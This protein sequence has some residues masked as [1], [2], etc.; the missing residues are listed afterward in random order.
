[1]SRIAHFHALS[2]ADRIKQIAES[3]KG[4][5]SRNI[6]MLPMTQ[7]FYAADSQIIKKIIVFC[8]PLR[9]PRTCLVPWAFAQPSLRHWSPKARLH[10]SD[11][12]ETNA[13]HL[14]LVGFQ[15]SLRRL[16]RD[17]LS[18]ACSGFV[19][20]LSVTSR[21]SR[22]QTRDVSTLTPVCREFDSRK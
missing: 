20:S 6:Y 21:A 7:K 14:E 18:R 22:R 9:R 8:D 12:L 2:S 15:I 17:K 10:Y 16:P 1:M 3:K 13:R 4:R 19:S 11:F 5:P